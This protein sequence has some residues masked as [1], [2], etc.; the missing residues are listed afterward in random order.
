MLTLE[1]V[2]LLETKIARAVEYVERVSTENIS[3]RSKLETYQ[4]RIDDLE[5]LVVRFKE[6]QSRIEDGILAALDRLNQ[7]EDALE[8]KLNPEQDRRGGKKPAAEKPGPAEK[9]E[10]A[11]KP[12]LIEKAASSA[13]EKPP[14]EKAVSPKLADTENSSGPKS[15]VQ[16]GSSEIFPENDEDDIADPP[17]DFAGKQGETGELDIF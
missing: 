13:A 3:L 15:A 5:V 12:G 17:Q 10:A 6:D 1:Q 8:N 14:V 7:F 4:K 9:P 16:G 2:K 11:G